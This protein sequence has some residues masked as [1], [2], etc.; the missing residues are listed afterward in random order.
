MGREGESVAS[1][2]AAHVEKEAMERGVV[3]HGDHRRQWDAHCGWLLALA[4]LLTAEGGDDEEGRN[5]E[6]L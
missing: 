3:A 1:M 4:W 5:R 2:M 6:G